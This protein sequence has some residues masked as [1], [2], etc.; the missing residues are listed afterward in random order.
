MIDGRVSELQY[1]HDESDWREKTNL[2]SNKTEKRSEEKKECKSKGQVGRKMGGGKEEEAGRKC[3]S[4]GQLI[5]P[6][7]SQSVKSSMVDPLDK[8]AS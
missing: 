1:V 6:S 7:T 2:S 5:N 4:V 8:P 3:Q